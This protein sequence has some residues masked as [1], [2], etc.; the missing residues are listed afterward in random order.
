MS[1]LAN[2]LTTAGISA[3]PSGDAGLR[4]ESS[5]EQ[6]GKAAASAGVALIELAT[7]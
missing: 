4:T 2:A 6:V 3:K 1:A 7:G 5:P